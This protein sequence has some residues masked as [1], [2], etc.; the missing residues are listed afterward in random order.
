MASAIHW[1][2]N[3]G[4]R[5]QLRE[6]QVFFTVADRCSMAKA[7]AEL[8]I[9]QPSV[10]AAISGLETSLGA[11]LFDRSPK[12]VELTPV[13]RALLMRG[14]AAFDE[15]RQAVRDIEYLCEPD[16]GEIRIGCPESIAAGFLPAVIDRLSQKHPRI[17]LAVTHVV[18]PTLEF[19][20]LDERKV[21]LVLALLAVPDAKSV[22]R[23]YVAE[24]LFEE[25]LCVVTGLNSPLLR[26]RKLN[27]D[28]LSRQPW[29]IGPVDS[30]GTTWIAEMFRSA[31][32]QFPTRCVTT[33]SVHLRYNM[34]ATGRFV[35]TMPASAFHYAAER[36]GLKMLPIKLSA[37]RWPL[38]AV[39][40]RNRRL[41]AVVD[42]FL[43]CARQVAKTR[44]VQG[45]RY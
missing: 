4:R 23:D 42:L 34:A 21:D 9:T 2:K 3:I 22:P 25:Q 20:E 40:L 30:P 44:R 1:E 17:S 11:E 45:I 41:S 16:V 8:G 10:S 36:Y 26:R 14:C 7:A 13:G 43:A 38:A 19:R 29:V 24:T 39:T 15:L 28:E 33:W 6:L 32:A 37:P 18:T 12:G 5:F 27:F 31:N 35:S